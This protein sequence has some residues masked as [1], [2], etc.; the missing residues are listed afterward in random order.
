MRT[1]IDHR[2]LLTDQVIHCAFTVHN[3]LGAG[4]LEKVYENDLA[5]ELRKSG[6]TVQQQSSIDVCYDSI[7]VGTYIADLV[8]D[9]GL[10]IELKAVRSLDTIHVAQALNYLRASGLPVCLLLNF[11]NPRLEIRR[12]AHTA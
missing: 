8:I 7:V 6:L 10:A 9:A 2:D 1:P 4:F 3:T 11:G 12:L 5:H